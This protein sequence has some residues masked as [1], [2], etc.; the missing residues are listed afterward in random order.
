MMFW[1]GLSAATLVVSGLAAYP[2]CALDLK[3]TPGLDASLPPV[4]E[5]VPSEP[6]VVDLSGRGRTIGSHGG[7]LDT[8]IG[9]AKDVRLIN[10]WG[11]ARLVGYNEKLEL[12][13]DILESVEVEEGRIFTLNTREGHKWSDGAPFGAED[14]R[15]YFEDVAL[16]EE[17]N[18]SGLPPFLTVDGKGP[19]FEVLSETAVRY[20]WEGPNPLFLGELAKS[21]PPFI[22]RPAH[23]LKQ[24]HEKYGDPAFI[25]T[26][27]AEVKARSWAPLHNKKDDM[28]DAQ[29]PDL[30]SLQPWVRKSNNSD[31]RFVLER[32]PFYHR[33]DSSGQQLP[34]ID[35]VIMTVAD[36][37]LIGAKTQ[38]GESDLQARNLSFS[39]IT[40]LKQGEASQGYTTAL[41][42]N[43]KG[44]EIAILPNLTVKDPDWR[45]LLRDKR[46]RH[47]LSLGIDRVMINRTLFFGLG[48]AGNDT[49][50]SASPLY[51]AEYLTKWATYDPDKANALLDEIGLTER[52]GEG[53]RLMA[54]GKPLE[55]IIETSGEASVQEDALELVGETWKEIGVKLY[56]KPSQRDILRERSITGELV[57]SVWW[58][59]ENGI[60]T[61][62]MPPSDFAPV[63]G[64]VLSWHSWGDYHETGGEGGEKPDWAPAE[65][66]MELYNA[67]L[68]SSSSEERSKIWTEMLDITAEETVRIGLVSEV[69]QPVVI[70]GVK[71][72]PLTAIYGWDPGSHFG[73]YRMDEFYLED[74]A[75]R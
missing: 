71:N 32:N 26:A 42:A 16:N 37:K 45:E 40:V 29:N 18:P 30:P 47:A 36:K 8:L 61:S 25:E 48:K 14:L 54:N 9:R 74:K 34:Y 38:A 58:G 20:S 1:K 27:A 43:A 59:I 65:R 63:S 21:R 28:Y 44:S 55:I 4:S 6:L 24:F 7:N 10:V 73:I 53:I 64:E 5:R 12:V 62:E 35:N 49:V 17:L 72:V 56:V 3:E 22:Y 46:F 19:K 67:W 52:N 11:Y 50:L 39:D 75:R 57:M 51:K 70:N 69:P 23:Y 2:A 68:R 13:P 41:W 31:Q 33:V 66:L 60:P 15:Y